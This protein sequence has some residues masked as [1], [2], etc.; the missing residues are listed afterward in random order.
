MYQQYIEEFNQL[1]SDIKFLSYTDELQLSSKLK[2]IQ[3]QFVGEVPAH[4][5]ISD[6]LSHLYHLLC[7][8]STMKSELLENCLEFLLACVNSDN[9]K[10]KATLLSDF[11]YLSMLIANLVSLNIFDVNSLI[12]ILTVIRE[13]LTYSSEM[14]EHNLKLIIEALLE[15]TESD[16]ADVRSLCFEIMANL[17]LENEAAKYLIMRTSKPSE[18]RNNVTKLPNNLIGFKFYMIEVRLNF[19][20]QFFSQFYYH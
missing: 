5:D 9:S 7:Q 2:L 13:L 8:A 15:Y 1:A 17:C 3:S 14:N 12:N 18:L 19:I 6:F 4:I 10:I 20:S 11:R 16:N